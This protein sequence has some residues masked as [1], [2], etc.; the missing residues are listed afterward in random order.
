MQTR[1]EDENSGESHDPPSFGEGPTMQSRGYP[2][3]GARHKKSLKF[4][5]FVVGLG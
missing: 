1:Q 4:H 2:A 5:T 3:G